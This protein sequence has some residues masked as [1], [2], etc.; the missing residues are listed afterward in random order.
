[1]STRF[2]SRI[3]PGCVNAKNSGLS[4]N[5]PPGWNVPTGETAP[6]PAMPTAITRPLSAGAGDCANDDCQ[7]ATTQSENIGMQTAAAATANE[8]LGML[9]LLERKQRP[10]CLERF[11]LADP[12]RNAG[13][14]S[15]SALEPIARRR[16][17]FRTSRLLVE[18]A[19]G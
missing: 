12:S 14:R 17:P 1:M 5:G 15:I 7:G 6:A 9:A 8:P 18:Q 11:L 4:R 13:R 2:P 3:F 19:H 16:K 10:G